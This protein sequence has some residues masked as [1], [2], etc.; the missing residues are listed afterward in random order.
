MPET[1]LPISPEVFWGVVS[2]GLFI[3]AC[4]AVGAL[5]FPPKNH[6][7]APLTRLKSN[8]GLRKVNPGLFLIALLM[9]SVVAFLLVAGLIG[10]VWDIIWQALP[11]NNSEFWDWRFALVKLTALTATLGAV[12]A[13]PITMQ[14]LRL[15]QL[16]TS[17]A[18]EALFNDKINA[19]ANDLHAQRQVTI[20]PENAGNPVDIWQDDVVKRNAAID[21]LEILV[22]ERPDT[23]PRVARMLCTYVRELSK[24][25]EPHPVPEEDSLEILRKW[26]Q[27]LK[28]YR[29][30]MENAAQTLGRLKTISSVDPSAISIDLRG[31]NLQEFNLNGAVLTN[32]KL[33]GANL[34][35]TQ[36][37]H[38]QMQETR[39][40]S[41]KMQG[42]NLKYT[43][44]QNATLPW[45]KMQIVDLTGADLRNADFGFA[46]MQ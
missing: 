7:I 28:P 23:A 13:F 26:A 9:W 32:A 16:Q 1:T 20:Y 21:Q 40:S 8:L 18:S 46:E 10:T 19:A 6:H 2:T 34:Q 14:R 29:S 22:I 30:D 27:S 11:A 33:I 5:L 17:T 35:N 15:T 25:Y 12:V 4:L 3:I 38:A 44:L 31:A 37:E 36:L 43:D 24:E 42:A 39:L 41:A 45:A